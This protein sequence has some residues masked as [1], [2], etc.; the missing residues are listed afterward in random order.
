MGDGHPLGSGRRVK[1]QHRPCP[2][3]VVR[4]VILSQRAE[5]LPSMRR[6]LVALAAALPLAGCQAVMYGT[7]S[8]FNQISI[9]MTRAEVI[10]RLGKPSAISASPPVEYLIYR[11]MAA[12]AAYWPDDYYVEIQ[13]GHVASFGQK[14]DF[15]TTKDPTLNVNVT[16]GGSPATATGK[17]KQLDELFELKKKGAITEAEYQKAKAELLSQ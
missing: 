7:A 4:V 11:K 9:G 8:D 14:G 5:E 1:G 12:V 10:Q 13:A 3:R 2:A 17:L 15:D 16:T 6:F